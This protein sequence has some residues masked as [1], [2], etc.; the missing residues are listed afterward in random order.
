MLNSTS[1][2]HA[3]QKGSVDKRRKKKDSLLQTARPMLGDEKKKEKTH[4]V[5]P[6]F[7]SAAT[8]ILSCKTSAEFTTLWN[9]KGPVIQLLMPQP[10]SS[11]PERKTCSANPTVTERMVCYLTV[12]GNHLNYSLFK[13]KS[14]RWVFLQGEG[15]REGT[16]R[17]LIEHCVYLQKYINIYNIYIKTLYYIGSIV[18]VLKAAVHCNNIH[19]A[20]PF[21]D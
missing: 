18:L 10:D 11:G 20:A 1:W 9:Q 13:I 14:S 12:C 3:V 5:F 4:I 15:E 17:G 19:V 6:S 16:G 2:I 8:L 7:I 21:G